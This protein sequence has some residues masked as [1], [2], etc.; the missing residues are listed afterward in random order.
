MESFLNPL[1]EGQLNFKRELWRGLQTLCTQTD[2]S[3]LSLVKAL[4][5]SLKECVKV[6]T[7]GAETPMMTRPILRTVWE[8]CSMFVEDVTSTFRSTEVSIIKKKTIILKFGL[9]RTLS[10]C[11]GMSSHSVSCQDSTESLLGLSNVWRWSKLWVDFFLTFK[12]TAVLVL[13]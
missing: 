4:S 5:Q 13:S 8:T 3:E 11:S 1:T 10:S 9:F 12:Q 7:H 2:L 6:Q